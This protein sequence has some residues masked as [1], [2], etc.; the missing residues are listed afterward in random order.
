MSL[1]IF[2]GIILSNKVLSKFTVEGKA[3][4]M[5]HFC[6]ILDL[7]YPYEDTKENKPTIVS[8]CN[9]CCNLGE[10]KIILGKIVDLIH[11]NN[12]PDD[13]LVEFSFTVNNHITKINCSEFIQNLKTMR[14]LEID[15]DFLDLEEVELVDKMIKKTLIEKE[16]DVGE[17]IDFG[18]YCIYSYCYC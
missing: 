16:I 11:S 17:N 18:Y 12:D 4:D 8:L 2:R 14:E 5:Y 9:N 15:I 6:D 3:N 10:N 7:P 13:D 1:S